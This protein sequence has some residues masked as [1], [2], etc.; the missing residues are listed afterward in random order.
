MKLAALLLAATA[1]AQTF[2]VASIRV[3]QLPL[4]VIAGY[5]ASG[6]RVEY[7]AWPLR[8]LV[9]EAYGLKPY[10]VAFPTQPPGADTD[11]YDV[12]AKAEGDKPRTRAEFRPLLQK[13]LSDRFHLQFHREG[14]DMPVYALVVG[15]SG[16]KL[17]ASSGETDVPVHFGVNGRNQFIEAKKMTADELAGA[18]RDCFGPDRPIVDRTGLTGVYD[19]KL[20]ATPAYRNTAPEPTD[21]SIFTAIQEQLGLKLEP[22]KATLQVLVV[23]HIEKPSDN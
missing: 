17:K 18:I 19:L 8:L 15:K 4:S 11:Y 5:K 1:F 7:E 22:Q 12:V 2:E 20:E 23:D 9:Q 10:E 3:R 21:L 16:P 13:L 14:R 6:P